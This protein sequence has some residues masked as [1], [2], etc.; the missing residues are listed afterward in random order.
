M[1]KTRVKLGVADAV[2]FGN[3]PNPES[4]GRFIHWLFGFISVVGN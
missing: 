3:H 4:F 2:G 1:L